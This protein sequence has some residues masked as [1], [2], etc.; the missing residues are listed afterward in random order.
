MSYIFISHDLAVVRYMSDQILVMSEGE[1][2][3]QGDA[4]TVFDHPQHAYT[5]KLLAAI[6]NGVKWGQTPLG[7]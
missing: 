5:Q 3:E 1:V 4:D 7:V 6:P 2:V